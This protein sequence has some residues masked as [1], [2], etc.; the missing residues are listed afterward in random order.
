VCFQDPD[1]QIFKSDV[2]GE[3]EFGPRR[4][5]R[6][7]EEAF[8]DA[9]AALGLVG[10]GDHL[11][12]HPDDLGETERKLLSIAAV[13]AMQTPVVVLDEPISGLD[14]RGVDL[15]RQVIHALHTAGRTVIGSSHDMRFVAESFDRVVLLD[16]G[17]VSLDG[18]PAEVFGAD[19]WPALRAS[20]LEPPHAAVAGAALALGSTPTEDAL[21]SA[22]VARSGRIGN[23]P[24]ASSVPEG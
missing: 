10:L 11:E 9:K 8:S 1:R 19:A 17:R 24:E 7:T 14:A 2:R 23:I 18:G 15:V 21:L 16:G 13:L 6:S 5:G 12:R 20:G 22:L 3:V 4:L